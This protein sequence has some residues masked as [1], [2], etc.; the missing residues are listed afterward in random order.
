MT[1]RAG[2]RSFAAWRSMAVL[3]TCLG[4]A[5]A[6]AQDATWLTSPG[7]NDWNT[8][9]N[10]ST[11]SVPTGTA[12]FDTS[13]TTT[14]TVPGIPS[15][16]TLQFNSTAPAYTFIIID[17]GVHFS[18]SGI[19]N[20]SAFRPSFSLNAT[21]LS[22]PSSLIF[23]GSGPGNANISN[24]NA[25]NT[26]F[27][28]ST[29]GTANIIN[30]LGSQTFGTQ[31]EGASTA[32]SATILNTNTGL[33]N[34]FGN[35]TAGNATLTNTGGQT[36]FFDSSSAGN[37]TI[38]NN[39]GAT[40]NFANT[41]TAG[42]ATIIDSGVGAVAFFANTSTAGSATITNGAGGQA[43]FVDNSTA[44]N[45]IVTNNLG[46]T[47]FFDSSTSASDA[48]ITNNSGTTSFF[49][50]S[51]A[52]SATITNN[53]GGVTNFHNTGTAGGATITNNSGGATQ[54]LD[55]STGG[56]ARFIAN[57]GG[58]FDIS[59]LSSAGMTAGSIE[60]AGSYLLGSKQLTVGGNNL[61]TDVSGVVSGA[62][63][64]LVMNGNG[65]LTLSGTNTY[66][67]GT[68]VS[69]GTL[70]IGNGGVTGSIVG[71]VTDNATF[72]INRSDTFTFGGNISGTG[73]FQQ[74]GTGTLILTGT[75]SYAGGTTVSAGTLQGNTT[76]LQGN[77]VNNAAVVFDQ[78][79]T[80][81]YAGAMSGTG[82]LTK[83]NAGTL[84]LTGTNSY[85]GATDI[86]AGTLMVNGSVASNTTVNAGGTLAGTGT[87][88]GTVTN[89]AAG[90]IS[91][92]IGTLTV[93]GNV[94]F[95]PG[96]IYQVAVDPNG[97]SGR[98]S[99]VGAPAT[100]NGGTVN[101]MAGAGTYFLSTRYTILNAT[102]GVT[103]TF[104]GVTSNLAFLTPSLSYDPND[105]FLT[106][107][108]NSASFG[109][110]A[111]THNQLAVA[112]TLTNI[113]NSGGGSSGMQ[114]ALNDIIG[115]S[116]PQ[117]RAAFDAI[118]GASLRVFAD[119][120]LSF[121]NGFGQLLAGRLGSGLSD[122]LAL[123]GLTGS[124]LQLATAPLFTDAAPVYAQ[125]GG[126]QGAANWNA[127]EA[128]HGLW[129]RAYDTNNNTS[130]DGN[131][132][133]FHVSGSGVS[134][135]V[136][137][138]INH[139]YRLGVAITNG[140]QHLSTD[141]SND[142]GSSDGTALAFYGQYAEGP[143]TVKAIVG[144]GRNSNSS[145]R[146]VVVGATGSVATG[147]FKSNEQ[148]LYAEA[149]YRIPEGSFELDPIAALS[150]VRLAQAG[151]TEQGAGALDLSV[152]AQTRTSTR[153]YLGAKTI[154]QLQAGRNTLRLEPR[155]L[156]SHEFGDVDTAPLSAQITGGGTAG[157]F[158][159]LGS[160]VKRDGALI[161]VNL[162]GEARENL[163]L[164]ADASAELRNGQTNAAFFVGLRYLW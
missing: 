152:N 150:Y 8:G 83:Q 147:D 9:A 93:S 158:Q 140:N 30:S 2:L 131:A 148:T 82:S 133:G 53:S 128:P 60:G 127:N 129:F 23:F 44:G 65:T 66:T 24:F 130:G 109:S 78:A 110:T 89:A 76:S 46:G 21:N 85:A 43:V 69:A 29:A 48:T 159:V 25:S 104:A 92:D 138:Q 55:T 10:W 50:S 154:S 73:G 125:A 11:G 142:T 79:A 113:V 119:A 160:T 132:N 108:R 157:S 124:G 67:G 3:L 134:L 15:I 6:Q 114:S 70:Q 38:T 27:L 91:P 161:G 107:Q 36:N 122:G 120:Q 32:G 17:S 19:V 146:N 99:V 18:I 71:D 52:G 149:A 31:F 22:L 77:I 14:I 90:I 139:A 86:N 58:T 47:T 64:S 72:A 137:G 54:F 116:A 74:N 84:I 151:F 16:A 117:A 135:G 13:S 49:N 57:A 28:N 94:T 20:N 68:T 62:G 40:A 100:L 45:A 4:A 59:G 143:W 63:G 126:T 141:N 37:A 105:V 88:F 163:S 162:S 145:A 12:T 123:P 121:M 26:V 7:T 156:W 101:V 164:Y 111:L 56:T 103:G 97:N 112:N 102:G 41:S 153:S 95:A 35:S 136:D 33:T 155:L 118:G 115:L 5:A 144:L 98:L 106:L 96:S 1:K 42:S 61:S 51:T 87:V 39:A 34:F 81:T 75:N 80:G